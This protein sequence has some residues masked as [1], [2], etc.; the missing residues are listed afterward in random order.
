MLLTKEVEIKWEHRNKGYYI[1]KGYTYTNVKDTFVVPLHI[2]PKHSRVIIDI[3]C[4]YCKTNIVQKT[5]DTYN[6]Q[7]KKSLIQ[8][9]CCEDCWSLK[10]SESMFLK[11]GENNAS[12][13]EEFQDKRVN[14]FIENFGTDN[15]MKIKE[16]V[17]KGKITNIERY[18]VSHAMKL[19]GE[20]AR[21]LVKAV[22]TMYQNGTGASSRP[23]R[24]IH[25]LVGGEHNYPIKTLM[26]D[27][28]FPEDKIYIEFDGG[29]HDL[30]VI[31]KNI[32]KKEQIAKEKNRAY[33]LRNRGWRKIHITSKKDY[34]PQDDMLL[35]LIELAREYFESGGTYFKIDID[36]NKIIKGKVSENYDFGK[37]M[38][39]YEK[40]LES[41][42]I[43][44][45]PKPN[46]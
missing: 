21:R 18:G 19:E 40:Q 20:H 25:D 29:G 28:A 10:L 4:D 31:K 35:K 34:I 15:P 6:A 32:T 39:I 12:N 30:Q 45:N 26:L 41:K 8:K 5:Y 13:V 27:I 43:K 11:Y 17:E 36:Q 24:Y 37:T 22:N 1:S 42:N 7:K 33:Y 46:K 3:L 2:V 38:R 23:Q 44:P 14:T 16:I 9:D